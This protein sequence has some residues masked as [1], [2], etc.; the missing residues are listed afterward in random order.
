MLF[1]P[2]IRPKDEESPLFISE[3][4][5]LLFLDA[6]GSERVRLENR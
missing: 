5:F 4:F 6:L 2:D 1:S 3:T